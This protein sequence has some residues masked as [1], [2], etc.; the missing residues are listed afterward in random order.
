MPSTP[1]PQP[2]GD[3]HNTIA[4]SHPLSFTEQLVAITARPAASDV[5]ARLDGLRGIIR[6][7][8]GRRNALPEEHV[9][10]EYVLEYLG[11]PPS[12]CTPQHAEMVRVAMVERG[13]MPVRATHMTGRGFP[14]C[15]RGY[16]RLLEVS[17]SSQ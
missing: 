13:W 8:N 2:S 5:W 11:I 14:A 1:L 7:R 4:P 10:T 16:A 9:S 17:N 6:R 12:A 15:V 3:L